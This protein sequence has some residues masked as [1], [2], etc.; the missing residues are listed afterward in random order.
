[1]AK[2]GRNEPCP[3]GSGKKYKKCCFGREPEPAPATLPPY[4]DPNF[5]AHRLIGDDQWAEKLQDR[6]GADLKMVSDR[7]QLKLP[8]AL[9]RLAQL[10]AREGDSILLREHDQWVGEIDL[11][12]P[13]EA[14]LVTPSEEFANRYCDLLK[15]I[16]ELVSLGRH[17]DPLPALDELPSGNLLE[18]KEQFFQD[19]MDEP[20]TKLGGL[21]P[22]QAAESAP[23]RLG[24][25]LEQLESKEER[26]PKKH[27]F[28]FHQIRQQLNLPS[29]GP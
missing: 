10:G 3:C 5:V 29:K 17:I 26:L 6:R 12:H 1:M 8:D 20:N 19:W 16:P 11:S 25:L 2:V 9:E 24:A 18:F 23:D 14:Y 7:F 27:R 15:T 13:G 22:R 21:T 4:L 28:S